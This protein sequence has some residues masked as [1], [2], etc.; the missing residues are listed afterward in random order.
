MSFKHFENPEK[1]TLLVVDDTPE[2]I[3][4]LKGVLRAEYSVRP[5][6]NGKIALKLAVKDPLPSLIL[7]DIMMPDMDG[8]EVCRRL[9]DDPKTRDIPV[10]FVTA[11]SDMKDELKGL[12]LGAVDYI[13]KPISPPLV[14]A[15]V[16]NHLKL[17]DA[18]LALEKKNQRLNEINEKLTLSLDNLSASEERFRSLVQTI[19]DI[20]YKIG[21][22]GKFTFLN[23]A[24]QRLGY[25]PSELLGKHYSEIIHVED[26]N[27][28]SR[29]E[30]LKKVDDL[31]GKPAPK[32][33]DEKRTG[34]RITSGL[35]IRLISKSGE[36]VESAEISDHHVFVEVNS[37][38]LYGEMVSDSVSDGRD[39]VFVGSV[40]V[41]RDISER[42]EAQEKLRAAKEKAEEAT[43]LK[44]KF[45]SLVAHDLRSPLSSMVG[46]LDYI[47][48]DMEHPL[49]E[50]HR[51]MIA[52]VVDNGRSLTDL[53]ED[54]LNIGKLQTGKITLE[55]CFLNAHYLVQDIFQRLESL[56]SKKG[57]LFRNELPLDMRIFA[58]Q[59][60]FS[61]VIQNLISNAIKFSQSGSVIRIFQP[62]PEAYPSE[63]SVI[64]VE[65]QGVGIPDKVISKLFTVSEKVSTPG[66]AGEQGTGFGLPFSYD[67][68]K[69]HGGILTVNSIENQGTTFFV[70]LTLV[71]PRILIVDDEMPER[72]ILKRHLRSLN[73]EI[74]ESAN[75]KEALEIMVER[76]P[77]LVISDVFMPIMDGFAL[78]EAIKSSTKTSWIPVIFI[79]GDQEVETRDR[80]FRMGVTDFSVKPI[81]VQDLLPRIRHFIGG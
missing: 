70:E 66:T 79:T 49:H 50:S 20:V 74:M 81:V 35:E 18:S 31:L 76:P 11:K 56:C 1:I 59:A 5:A 53:I 22:N 72:M 28:V 43:L 78:L 41:I 36:S 24:I 16:K 47:I 48:E 60:L 33:F 6:I 71:R 15:R 37:S 58:D 13:T 42:K 57:V 45:V 65:D 80:A 52:D 4:V 14:R 29:K 39:R 3:D 75:G 19:P 44:D 55:K 40:G 61:E 8:Y 38:G 77:H 69:A 10:I 23:S 63:N 7:L 64:A 9:K 67:I 26:V 27:R 17:K 2:N 46:L 12:E 30:V 25:H 32:L 68:V 73:V 54:I 51:E 21:A 62:N 34:E